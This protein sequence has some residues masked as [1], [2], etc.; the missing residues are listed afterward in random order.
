M[1]KLVGKVTEEEKCEIQLLFER[2]NA[3]KEL[4]CILTEDNQMLYEKLLKDISETSSRF[5]SWWDRM[6]EQYKWERTDNGHWE[7]DFSSNEIYLSV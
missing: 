5:Q 2:K 7:I 3:L 6:S 1:K 4:A